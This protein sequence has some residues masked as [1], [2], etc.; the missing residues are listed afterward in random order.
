MRALVTCLLLLC[1]CPSSPHPDNAT[2]DNDG[3]SATTTTVVAAAPSSATA[4]PSSSAPQPKPPALVLSDSGAYD[5]IDLHIDTPWKVHFK[6]RDKSLPKGHA[7]ADMLARGSYAAVVYPIYIPDYI[8]NSNPRIK[9]ADEIFATIDAIVAHHEAFVPAARD[10]AVPDDKIAVYVAIEGAGAFHEDI[11]QIDRFIER[12]VRLV[13]PVH[14]RN[15]KLAS[16]ATGKKDRGLTDLGKAFCRRVYKAGALVDVSHMSDRS[17]DDLQKIAVELKAP[18][19]ATHSNARKLAR[20]KRNLTDDQLAAIKET[21]GIAGLNLHRPFV[22]RN[23]KVRMK[24]V[25]AQVM[26]MIEKAGVDH[27][28]IGSDYD[29]GRP[30]SALKDA[31]QMQA[32]GEALIAAGLDDEEVRKI[33]GGNALRILEYRPNQNRPNQNRPNQNRPNQNRAAP[34]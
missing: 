8:H 4:Q 20:H 31:S 25:V 34:R 33:F 30:V 11:A 28:A 2:P 24:D 6:G 18:I 26:H 7:T 12:G 22:K 16:S 27:V 1:G 13:G 10:K 32:L 3:P 29:G 15:N 14:A 21:K 9:D 23:G 19:V 17:F 5:V